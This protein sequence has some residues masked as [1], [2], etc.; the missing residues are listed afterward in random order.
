M[1]FLRCLLLPIY[2]KTLIVPYAAVAEV[3]VLTGKGLKFFPKSNSWL[4]GEFKWRDLNI[5]LVCL[6]MNDQENQQRHEQ[7]KQQIN[8]QIVNQQK[9]EPAFSTNGKPNLHIAIFNRMM[10]TGSIDFLG[11][12]L[13]DLP[14]MYRCKQSDLVFIA[15]ASNPYLIMEVKVREKSAFIP[16]ILW[17]EE[18]LLN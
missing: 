1:D 8:Q 13:Q 14:V 12:L 11:V 15:K 18:R 16:D 17:I 7:V 9:N 5:P 3:V 2:Q 10:D 4:L 6:E